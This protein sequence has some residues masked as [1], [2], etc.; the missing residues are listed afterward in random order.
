MNWTFTPDEFVHVWRETD[1]DRPPYPLR[2]LET[3]GTEHDAETLT[4]ALAERLPHGGDPD[5]SA[6]LRILAE[7][8]TRIVVIGSTDRPGGEL[9]LLA[10]TIYDRAV[11]AVQE[12]G[13]T[14]EFGDRIRISIGH[15]TKLGRRIVALLPKSPPGKEPAR[16]AAGYAVRD[17]EAAP[18]AQ[19]A[20]ARIRRLLLKPHA[21]Q[22]HIRIEP[23]LDRAVPPA[24]VHYTW[25]DVHNDGRYL[26]RA[27]DEVRITPASA[28][29]IAGHLQKRIPR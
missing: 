4:A 1:V 12:P 27:D 14:P 25:I 29:Q 20:A 24:P 13:P 3:P 17:E 21:A 9:R 18:T 7:P 2:I 10:G 28:E 16:A 5:L 8:H 15:S 26:I 11:L 19:S 6:C 23:R 22:G